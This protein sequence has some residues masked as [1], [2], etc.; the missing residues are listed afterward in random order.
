RWPACKR[1]NIP[2][3]TA[4]ILPPENLP[5]GEATRI[6]PPLVHREGKVY[7]VNLLG[8]IVAVVTVTVAQGRPAQGARVKYCIHT[9]SQPPPNL[10]QNL[11][12]L[13][14]LCGFF[15]GKSLSSSA[16][17]RSGIASLVAPRY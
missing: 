13:T 10:P 3:C 9:Y 14:F 7:E 15:W 2:F 1:W 11:E 8:K 4:L 6:I 16:C 12:E 5:P 17:L